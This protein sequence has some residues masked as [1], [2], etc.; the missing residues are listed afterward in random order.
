MYAVSLCL[1]IHDFSVDDNN[2]PILKTRN[3][4]LP[5]GRSSEENAIIEGIDTTSDTFEPLKGEKEMASKKP[6]GRVKSPKGTKPA[7]KI[8]DT[9]KRGL[10]L[11]MLALIVI[12]VFLAI[13]LPI[14]YGVTSVPFTILITLVGI[15]GAFSSLFAISPHLGDAVSKV[16]TQ[17][18]LPN[19]KQLLFIGSGCLLILLILIGVQRFILPCSG[20]A[21]SSLIPNYAPVLDDS[22]SSNTQHLWQANQQ[23]SATCSFSDG[24]YQIV[25]APKSTGGECST[26]SPDTNYTNFVYQIKMAIIQ[27]LDSSSN[28][29][30]GPIFC[31][32]NALN[33]T[34][35]GIS[36]N[37]SGYWNFSELKNAH[38][39]N[40]V[41]SKI[42][43][44]ISPLFHTSE[45]A[46]N[47]IT[48]R[49]Q[50]N[51]ITA[52]ANGSTFYAASN[53]Q[54]CTGMIGVGLY[55]GSENADVAF[56]DAKV[57]LL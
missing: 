46:W 14:Q 28:G 36:F 9:N 52:Q 47:Y 54:S 41:S 33:G 19:R 39:P 44:G 45:G 24:D 42:K 6:Q 20:D 57:W 15:L 13:Y 23:G 26:Q 43:D 22:L 27:G 4:S 17:I 10:G 12:T 29:V 21:C 2:L 38:S 31:L 40:A 8:D 3:F 34:V 11:L 51:S 1:I 53:L 16:V 25:A 18:P 32:S 50:G 37:T 56:S 5:I 55:P 48:I 30:A 35:Y 7:V 49:V